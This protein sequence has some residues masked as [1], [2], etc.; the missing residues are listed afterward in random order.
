MLKILLIV[1]LLPLMAFAQPDVKPEIELP[2]AMASEIKDYCEP[3]YDPI[4]EAYAE[5]EG[6]RYAKCI[7]RST[8]FWYNLIIKHESFMKLSKDFIRV[9]AQ[10]CINKNFPLL[11]RTRLCLELQ[12]IDIKF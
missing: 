1:L 7:N 12:G 10:E 11:H 4:S 6:R 8:A 3:F 9:N 5:Q 2:Q